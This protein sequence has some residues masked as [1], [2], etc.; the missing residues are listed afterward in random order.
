MDARDFKTP[1][2]ESTGSGG[3]FKL[4]CSG[5]GPDHPDITNASRRIKKSEVK[6]C[7]DNGVREIVEV[8]VG[9]DGIV[10]ANSKV[11]SAFPLTYKHMFLALAKEVPVKGRWLQNP[12][13]KWSDIDSSLPDVAIEVLGPPPTSGT[14]DAFVE[15]VMDKGCDGL[16][17]VHLLESAGRKV[18]TVYGRCARMALY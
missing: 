12:H 11:A 2:I 1:I 5:V 14:R 4:F 3:G 9:Y 16:G 10:I 7:A 15:L 6:N 13:K 18:K 17:E 8:R